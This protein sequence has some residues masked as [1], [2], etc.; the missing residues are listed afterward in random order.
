MLGTEKLLITE[1]VDNGAMQMVFW[2]VIN[3]GQP[4]VFSTLT[5]FCAGWQDPALFWAAHDL[6]FSDQSSLWRADRDYYVQTA[7]QVGAE[8]A[9]FESCYDDPESIA[10]IQ[11]LDQ[12]RRDR[13]IFGQPVFDINGEVYFGAAPYDIFAGIIRAEL[14]DG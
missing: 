6:M 9:T 1:F 7:L 11:N 5:A 14:P 10:H 8:Q 3:H 12:I 2:P 13:G 4:S